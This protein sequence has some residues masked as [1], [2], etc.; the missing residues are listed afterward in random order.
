[1]IKKQFDSID[2]VK[3]IAAIFIVLLHSELFSG[4]SDPLHLFIGSG[5]T[6]LC[7]PFFFVASAFFYFR[8]PVNLENTKHY[9]SRLL[10]LYL[11]WFIVSIPKTVY[12]RFISSEYPLGITVFRFIRSFFVTSTFSGSWFIVSCIFC[13]LLYYWLSKLNNN[14]RL[15]ITVV[16]CFIVYLWITFTSAYGALVQKSGLSGFY[17]K[18]EMLLG[19]PYTNFL[20]GIPYFAIGQYFSEQYFDNGSFKISEKASIVGSV[21]S[22]IIFMFEVFICNKYALSESTDCYIMLL[23]FTFCIFPL[24]V[25]WDIELKNAKY[26]RIASTVVFFSHF[27]FLFITELAEWAIKISIP[28]FAKFAFALICSLLLTWIML[29]LQNVKGFKWVKYFY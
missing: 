12:D 4:I 25:N 2:L 8:K 14:A 20:V 5:V 29:I 1:M 9:C 27:L 22:F 10:I 19:K 11:A 26:F 16:L 13:A 23:P 3:F 21:L 28:G 17:E 7:V 15:I 6:R 18:Y 24:I